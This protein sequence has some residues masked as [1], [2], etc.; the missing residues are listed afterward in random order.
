MTDLREEAA[1]LEAEIAAIGETRIDRAALEARV[2][3]LCERAVAQP[4]AEAKA[5]APHLERLI[6]ALDAATERLKTKA[7]GD[8]SP[9]PSRSAAVGAAAYGDA[10]KRRQR[11]Y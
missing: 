3:S 11:G 4:A 2:A 8:D 10:I 7:T 5:L 1:G 9:A 6:A